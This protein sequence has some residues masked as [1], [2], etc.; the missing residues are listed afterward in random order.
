MKKLIFILALIGLLILLTIKRMSA[1]KITFRPVTEADVPLVYAWL[2]QPHVSKWWPTPTKDLFFRDWFQS[3]RPKGAFPYLVMVNQKPIG[4]IQYYSVDP[5]TSPWLPE[6]PAHSLGIDQFIGDINYLGKGYGSRMI[7]KFIQYLKTMKPE[8]TTVIVD[9]D[10]KNSAAVKC[11]TNVGFRSVGE[12]TASWGAALVMRH[13][14][15]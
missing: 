12:Y 6:L 1:E 7:K 5:T 4:L 11:Y 15:E 9:P 14:I 10:P 2:Q 8:T 13:D 3:L